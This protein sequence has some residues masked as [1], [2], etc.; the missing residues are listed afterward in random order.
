MTPSLASGRRGLLFTERGRFDIARADYRRAQF[1]QVVREKIMSRLFSTVVVAVLVL[2]GSVGSAS[3]ATLEKV[4]H[5]VA[6]I[7][8]ITPDMMQAGTLGNGREGFLYESTEAGLILSVAGPA[9]DVGE[10]NALISFASSRKDGARKLLSIAALATITTK[11]K[12]AFDWV[13]EASKSLGNGRRAVFSGWKVSLSPVTNGV[14]LASFTNL[15][16]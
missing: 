9:D 10:V 3:A 14:I 4:L 13:L 8:V 16:E 11:T 12:E 7:K 15:A 6:A 2:A 1:G 5:A